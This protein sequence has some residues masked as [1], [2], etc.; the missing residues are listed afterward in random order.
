MMYTSKWLRSLE[1]A[2]FCSLE[3]LPGRRLTEKPGA[4]VEIPA[5]PFS[6]WPGNLVGKL[7]SRIY[8]YASWI[9]RIHIKRGK[10]R[11]LTNWV[12][13]R[14]NQKVWCLIAV[15]FCGFEDTTIH[16]LQSFPGLT[17]S[18]CPQQK[19]VELKR[20]LFTT[21]IKITCFSQDFY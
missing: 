17:F 12:I 18:E 6:H 19:I 20:Y 21:L 15:V 13:S 7:F 16:L 11:K 4:A 14:I 5:E 1:S 8:L 9:R 10:S 3:C 2:F